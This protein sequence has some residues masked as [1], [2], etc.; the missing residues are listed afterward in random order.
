MKI[1]SAAFYWGFT[2]Y[3]VSDNNL[4]KFFPETF[5]DS[6]LVKA[7]IESALFT[8]CGGHVLTIDDV[9]KSDETIYISGNGFEVIYSL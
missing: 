6:E 7:K 9:K 8:L 3:P 4:K 2:R 1:K 5:N